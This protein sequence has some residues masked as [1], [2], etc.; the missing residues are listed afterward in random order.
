[1]TAPD[2]EPSLGWVDPD[3]GF[4]IKFRT[5]DGAS[6]AIENIQLEAEPANLF[7]VPQGYG[8]FDPRALIDRIKQGDV[9]VEPP[10]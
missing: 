1:M 8:K 5:S 4:P 10:K 3:L 2:Q 7:A 6:I 9:W